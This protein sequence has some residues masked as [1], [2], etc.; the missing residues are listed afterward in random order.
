[1]WFG[2][3]PICL[4]SPGSPG[5]L[6]RTAGKHWHWGLYRIQSTGTIGPPSQDY[7]STLFSAHFPHSDRVSQYWPVF[8]SSLQLS[9]QPDYS[10]QFSHYSYSPSP[11]MSYFRSGPEASLNGVH[12][13]SQL[14]RVSLKLW[15]DCW[16]FWKWP[17]VWFQTIDYLSVQE[18]KD[19]VLEEMKVKGWVPRK[20]PHS[21]INIALIAWA[22]VAWVHSESSVYPQAVGMP[23]VSHN[24]NYPPGL[25]NA[26]KVILTCFKVII[27]FLIC[28]LNQE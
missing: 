18:R 20:S 19:I 21:I 4:C 16:L 28:F 14:N 3:K 23:P 22:I 5:P 6:I 11:P 8:W 24:T 27:I 2:P 1:M 9:R 12:P 10:E 17:L 13:A 7:I 15:S 25:G 26:A